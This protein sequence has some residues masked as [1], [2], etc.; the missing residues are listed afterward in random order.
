MGNVVAKY[1]YAWVASTRWGTLNRTGG[2]NFEMLLQSSLSAAVGGASQ[3]PSP[4]KSLC[5]SLGGRGRPMTAMVVAR[6]HSVIQGG[7]GHPCGKVTV[8]FYAR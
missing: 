7:L 8:W 2:G 6:R 3:P 1:Q 5:T 4:M